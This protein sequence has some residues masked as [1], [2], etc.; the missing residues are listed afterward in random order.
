MSHY[1]KIVSAPC[2]DLYQYLSLPT[3]IVKSADSTV[4]FFATAQKNEDRHT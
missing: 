4:A 1:I 2:G 3:G